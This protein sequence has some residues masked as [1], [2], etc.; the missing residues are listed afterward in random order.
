MPAKSARGVP[1]RRG[2]EPP[3]G[4]V[5]FLFTDIE[6]STRLARSLADQYEPLLERHRSIVRAAFR[7]HAGFEV[8]TEGDS[9]F[10]AFGSP[11][12]ALR[13]AA[14]AQRALTE[15]DWPPEADLRVR[16][17]LHLGEAKRRGGDYVGL[18]VHR[19]ARIAA[20]GHGGQVLVSSAMAAVVGDRLPS[21]LGLRDLGEYRLKDFDTAAHLYQL[22]GPG[23]RAEF[24]ALRSVGRE[25]TN[26]AP[27]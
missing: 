2:P 6:G 27:S 13:A 24:P 5:A 22:L 19:A 10:V 14:D 16:M 23:L 1:P 25:L 18:E 7:R 4:T 11:L 15:T 8:G 12:H 26:L 17:G 21:E 20:A 3:T 9:F